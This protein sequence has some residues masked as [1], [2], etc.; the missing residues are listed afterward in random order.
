MTYVL[1]MSLAHDAVSPLSDRQAYSTRTGNIDHD[2]IRE[3]AM[4]LAN[5]G[6]PAEMIQDYQFPFEVT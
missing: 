1:K 5:L 4:D 3:I 6:Y 2:R